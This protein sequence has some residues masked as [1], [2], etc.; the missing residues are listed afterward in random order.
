VNIILFEPHEVGT[1]LP[2]RDERTI[3]LL[4]VLHKKPG[5]R[6]DAGILGGSLGTG[7]I[8]AI[9]LD[10]ALVYSLDLGIIPPPRI[11]IRAAVGFS[12]PIQIR[13]ILRDLSNLGLAAVDL[14][15]TELGEKSYRDTKLFSGGGARAA[16]IEGAI[17]ARD[18]TIP[19]LSVYPTLE[20]WLEERPWDKPSPAPQESTAA[21]IPM[22]NP[23]LRPGPLL[24]ALDNIRPSGA[25][26]NLSPHR[27]S[28]VL[29]IGPE[30]GWSDQERGMLEE[31]GFVR[32]SLGKR[33]LRT[34]TACVAAATLAMEKMGELW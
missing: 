4:K 27:R 15:G 9:R 24:I 17:Q 26:S 8:E 2:K 13:R 10:G 19:S 5:D 33:A 25:M 14:M 22:L 23:F 7:A 34:E 29:A 21:P 11:S 32:F 1:P 16:L 31:A 30:R 12:R 20:V 28:M 3:H 18:T 6:F